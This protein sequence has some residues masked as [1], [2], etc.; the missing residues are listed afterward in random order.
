MVKL[1]ILK[2]LDPSFTL[3]WKTSELEGLVGISQIDQV[4][5]KHLVFVKNKK[6]LQKLILQ[7]KNKH[8]AL[9]IIE[10]KFYDELLQSADLKKLK[11][12]FI[13]GGTVVDVNLAISYFSKPFYDLKFLENN[14]LVDGRQMGSTTIHPTAMIAQGVFIGENVTIGENVQILSGTTILSNVTILENTK[15]YP[16][17]SIYENVKIGKNCRIHSGTIIGAD[18]FGYNF[19]KGIHHK[20]WHVGGVEI[21]NNVE[22]GANSTIDQGT[23][24]PTKIGDGSKLDNQVQVGHNCQLGMGVILCGQV[25]IA[26]STKIGD[27]SVFGGK[28]GVGP[29]LVIGK[30]VQVAGNAMVNTD[31]PDGS[32][33]AG[34]PARPIKE[35]MKGLAWVRKMSLEKE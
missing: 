13:W 24:T 9:I 11:D 23:F 33:V 3:E 14:F 4:E 35:W 8:E 1:E 22:I 26:G 6:F 19:S 10:K 7:I 21:G 5:D 30:G 20:V 34:H 28:A 2:N 29:D 27:F 25:G 12:T 31:W 16:N 18:G 17:V 32:I 15:I